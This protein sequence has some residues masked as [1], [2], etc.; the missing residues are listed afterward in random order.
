MT[1]NQHRALIVIDVQSDYF[2]EGNY[3]LWEPEATLKQTLQLIEKAR[4]AEVPVVFI[5]HIADKA[6]GPAPFFNGDSPGV[7]LHAD[8]S[9]VLADTPLVTKSAADAFHQTNLGA[10]LDE[11]RITD[12]LIC[13]MMTQ[14]CVTHTAISKSAEKYDVSVVSDCCATVD[15]MLHLIALNALSTRVKLVESES[16]F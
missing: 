14:N 6:K 1:S 13:G 5:Q 10:T 4:A 3:P 7:E 15:K 16:L 12:L 9:A 8:I 11:M 2:P